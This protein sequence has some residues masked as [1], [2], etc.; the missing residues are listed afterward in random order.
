MSNY[1]LY[2]WKEKKQIKVITNPNLYTNYTDE[3]KEFN[4]FYYVSTNLK[5]LKELASQLKNEWIKEAENEFNKTKNIKIERIFNK[6]LED[7]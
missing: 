7:Y 3:I 4:D 5:K 1:G 6:N 2:H